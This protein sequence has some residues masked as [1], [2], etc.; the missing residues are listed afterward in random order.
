VKNIVVAGATGALGSLVCRALSNN[1]R[2]LILLGRNYEKLKEVAGQVK[3]QSAAYRID[4]HESIQDLCRVFNEI[5]NSEGDLHGLVSLLGS[6]K[7]M[8]ISGSNYSDWLKSM[9]VNFFSNVELLRGFSEASFSSNAERKVVFLSSVAATRGDL[10]LSSYS[11]S[12]AALESLVR[13]AALEFS[14]KKLL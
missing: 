1:H 6:A 4:A 3:G 13:G 9:N 7:P 10:G 2:K 11:A 12:K 8:P 14:R 5:S